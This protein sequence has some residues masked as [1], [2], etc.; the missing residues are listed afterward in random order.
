[1][2]LV[3]FSAQDLRIIERAQT[4]GE[5]QGVIDLVRERVAQSKVLKEF[6]KT[7]TLRVEKYRWKEAL[8]SAQEVLGDQVTFPKLTDYMY[9][10]RINRA[11]MD[12][13]MD[14]EFVTKLANY[15]KENM[16]LPIKFDFMICQHKRIMEG[17]FPKGRETRTPVAMSQQMGP[18][19]PEE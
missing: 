18:E 10:Q 11:I 17:E 2:L 19:L 4:P 5:I 12:E 15:V 8:K 3:R 16:R 13:G 9:Y 1:M 14:H 6:G 7:P